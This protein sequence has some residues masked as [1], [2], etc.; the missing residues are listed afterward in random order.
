[1]ELG[2]MP[3]FTTHGV[4]HLVINNQ[5]GFTTAA[6][7]SE[8]TSPHV[9]NVAKV[10]GAPVIHVNADDIEAVCR[11]ASLAERFRQR[12]GRSVMLD[13]VGYRRRGHNEQVGGYLFVTICRAC[14][15]A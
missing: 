9:T 15:N 7:S 2:V 12:F 1:M 10:A 11:A 14:S 6:R 8:H 5:I 13:V 4:L 3:N